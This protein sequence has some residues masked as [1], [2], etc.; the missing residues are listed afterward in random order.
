MKKI[1]LASLFVLFSIGGFAQAFI[2][3]S[4][5]NAIHRDI[6]SQI[7]YPEKEEPEVK[8]DGLDKEDCTFTKN[9]KTF[10]L[11]GK[12]RIVDNFEDLKVRIVDNFEDVR[13]CFSSFGDDCGE[14]IIVDNFE[15]VK[16]RL[17]DN[18]EDIKVRLVNANEGVK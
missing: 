11:Y 6:T 18:F 3:G 1:L 5:S 7:V 15:D 12:V 4:H 8:P 2:V 14:V 17:V 10:N 9:G 13:V 16:V